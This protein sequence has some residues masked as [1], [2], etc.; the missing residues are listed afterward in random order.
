MH[1]ALQAVRQNP[2]VLEVRGHAATVAFQFDRAPPGLL[3]LGL[4]LRHLH[5]WSSC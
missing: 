3:Q 5:M 2:G 4:Q 1:A